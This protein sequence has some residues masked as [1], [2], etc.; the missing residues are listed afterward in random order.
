MAK[1][2]DRE[3]KT[4]DGKKR[5]AVTTT[6]TREEELTKGQVGHRIKHCDRR[7]AELGDALAAVQAERDEL[8]A[9]KDQIDD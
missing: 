5:L 9:L 6:V 1:N 4:K 7:I 3:V 2:V 8:A